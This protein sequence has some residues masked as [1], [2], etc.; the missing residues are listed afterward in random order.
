MPVKLPRDSPM[1]VEMFNKLMS[2]DKKV[3]DGQLR[4]ILLRGDLGGC[5]FT[6]EF[7][8]DAMQETIEEFV[9]DIDA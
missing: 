1:T 9:K 7:D 8:T 5:V 3:A 2:L 4:L 6:G